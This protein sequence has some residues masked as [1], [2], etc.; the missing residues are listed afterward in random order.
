MLGVRAFLLSFSSQPE[1]LELALQLLHGLSE[2]R[3]LAGDARYVLTVSHAPSPWYAW[4][5][6][7]IRRATLEA[8]AGDSGSRA[9]IEAS[10]ANS[11]KSRQATRGFASLGCTVESRKKSTFHEVDRE[12]LV[13]TLVGNPLRAVDEA[14]L[15]RLRNAIAGEDVGEEEQLKGVLRMLG[16]EIPAERQL[17]LFGKRPG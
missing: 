11:D 9:G 8:E 12:K 1:L 7:V 10:P 14:A 15:G 5:E 16:E 3:Q 4:A 17:P 13:R 6:R 2:I